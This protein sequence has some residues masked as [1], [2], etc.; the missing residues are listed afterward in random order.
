VDSAGTGHG[1]PP[2]PVRVAAAD[3]SGRATGERKHLWLAEVVDGRPGD[4]LRA[5]REEVSAHLV[6]L[7]A[8][9]PE[10]VVGLDFGFSLPAW[11]LDRHGIAGGPEL[12][13]G[14]ARLERWLVAC[15]PPFWGRPGCPRPAGS[16]EQFRATEL[17][18]SAMGARPKSVFQVGGAGSVGTGSLRGMPTLHR[19]RQAGWAVW[20][21][22]PPRLPMVVEVWPRLHYGGPMVKSSPGAREPATAG[23]PPTWRAAAAASDD[24]FDAAVTAWA[25][26]ARVEELVGLPAVDDT[27]VRREG[28]IW[29]VPLP[30]R[31]GRR[32]RRGGGTGP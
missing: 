27:T 16:L 32:R 29:G 18:A 26:A 23:L 19:L 28:W 15:Q 31:P 6:A 2:P 30:G 12:W 17:A 21:F 20:P 10:V 1:R 3:W 24:A 9:S 25:M 14:T 5:S 11:F 8:S 4:L 7:G 22:D 13:A